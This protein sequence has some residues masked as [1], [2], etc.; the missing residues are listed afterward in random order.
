MNGHVDDAV[1]GYF[2]LTLIY[3]RSKEHSIQ[4]ERKENQTESPFAAV[5]NEGNEVKNLA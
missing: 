3:K 2:N 1:T 4:S 5:N